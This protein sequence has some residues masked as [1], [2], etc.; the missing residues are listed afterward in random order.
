MAVTKVT[1]IY[2]TVNIVSQSHL[3][4]NFLVLL[5]LKFKLPNAFKSQML[6]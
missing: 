3:K 6:L 2:L 1:K 4:V 5:L